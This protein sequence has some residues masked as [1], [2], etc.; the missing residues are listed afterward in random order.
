MGLGYDAGTYNLLCAKKN[1]K[2]K[3]EIVREVNAFI[4]IPLEDR[5]TFNMMKKHGD[6]PLIEG[7]KKAWACGEKAMSIART[8]GDMELRRPMKHGCVNPKEKKAFGILSTMIHSMIGEVRYDG[9]VLCYSTPANALN[10]ET[11]IDYHREVLKQ[12]FE[13]YEFNGKKVLPY[14]INE[15]LALVYAELQH[16]HLT[17]IGISCLV[18]GTKIYTKCGIVN[19]EDVKEDDFVLTHC[20][21]W[22]KVNKVIQ[23]PYN[24]MMTSL[25]VTGYS[26]TPGHYRFVDNHELYIKRNNQW[27]WT[28]CEEVCQD[29]IVGEPI[30]KQNRSK[31]RPT[32]TLCERI[33]SSKKY[34]KK[35]YDVTANIQRLVGYFLGD[36]SISISEGALQFDFGSHEERN[37]ADVQ[38]ILSTVFHKK[39]AKIA[40]GEN[41]ARIKC[42]SKS[43]VSW[44][45]NHCYDNLGKRYPWELDRINHCDCINLL[46]GLIRSD[47]HFSEKDITFFNTNTHLIFLC[48]Q[49]F[50]RLGIAAS[51]S[52]RGP[53]NG[54]EIDGRKICGQLDEWQV[55]S[56]AK[57]S[58]FQSLGDIL[59]N[60]DC[61]N[62]RYA[63]K[64][65]IED[66]FCCS[67]VQKV[68][69]EDYEGVV[70]DLQVEE[71]H[72]FSGP[73]LTIHNC[74]AGMINLC[75]ANRSIPVFQFSLV[76]SGD[77][78]DAQA[79]KA[80][81]VS[82]TRINRDKEKID[83]LATPKDEIERAII[84]QYHIMI[85]KTIKGIK[86]GLEKT[87]DKIPTDEPIDIIL[88][89]GAASPPGFEKV[90]KDTIADIGFPCGVGKVRRPSDYLF[91]VVRGCLEAAEA[92]EGPEAE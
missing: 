74:G 36:G 48:K 64:L 81:A 50:S 16:K 10:E 91:A 31:N 43:L 80:A 25:Q 76:N 54:G 28:G 30:L 3:I 42:Y 32:M 13:K 72:S 75:F 1:D 58:S 26:D 77:W 82:P 38:E 39:S 15:G 9:E 21:R 56:G 79:A 4:E 83:L 60:L 85:R 35:H 29:D 41:C 68:E 23:K 52:T 57:F 70:Y 87:S 46:C 71:D 62:N 55:H 69:H 40:H 19:I 65:F 7:E 14:P 22:R 8:F 84:T 61:S 51:I 67:K 63:Q 6:V 34:S 47:G 5:F 49:L 78:I 59:M 88:G 53:R 89:G 33:T 18:P 12:I 17:G 73:F 27:Q 44:F 24:G 37:I 66:G 86:Q 20:G 11:D 90:V 2:G 45:K 92:V